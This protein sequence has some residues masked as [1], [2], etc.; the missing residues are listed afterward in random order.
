MMNEKKKHTYARTRRRI[1]LVLLLPPEQLFFLSLFLF[2]DLELLF[3]KTRKKTT[4]FLASFTS[5][6]LVFYSVPSLPRQR[7][8]YHSCEPC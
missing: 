8:E 3:L 6:E 4:L 5:F 2:V 7:R 1:N